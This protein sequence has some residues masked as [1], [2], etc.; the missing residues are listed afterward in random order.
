MK[1]HTQIK[2]SKS[3]I[4]VV[5]VLV[6]AGILQALWGSYIIKFYNKQNKKIENDITSTFLANKDISFSYLYQEMQQLVYGSDILDR[7]KQANNL[8]DDAQST[9]FSRNNSVI[10]TKELFQQMVTLY[11]D[12]M[13]FFYYD[14]SY[15]KIVEYGRMK[16]GDRTHFI[17]C[18]QN[19]MKEGKIRFSRGGK[20][21]L[22]DKKYL[23]MITRGKKGY[24]GCFMKNDDFIN[25]IMQIFS[26]TG[27]TVTLYDFE[28]QIVYAQERTSKG[29]MKGI[30][31]DTIDLENT[32]WHSMT[33]ADFKIAVQI[34]MFSLASPL[35][36]QFV[37]TIVFVIYLIS[38]VFVIQYTRKNI[39]GQAKYFYNN[40]MMFSDKVKFQEE[41][42]I[43]EFS[44]AGKVL[45]KLADEI[46][47]LKINVY[48]E[49]LEKKKVELD[50][51]QLQ[52]RPHFY[53]NC[54]NVINSLAQMGENEQIQKIS[55]HVS[56]YLRFIFNKSMELL[57]I[58]EELYFVKNYLN[59]I[60]SVNGV[61]CQLN[62]DLEDGLE[63]F[64]VPPL[65]IQTFVENSVKH[66]MNIEEVFS[67]SIVVKKQ[68]AYV[69]ITITDSGKGIDSEIRELWNKGIYENGDK[70]YHVGI[71]NAA[72]R[73][74]MLYGAKASIFFDILSQGGSKTVIRLP[75]NEIEYGGEDEL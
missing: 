10:A 45:N 11:G 66:G 1:K 53:I 39:L 47:K 26:K 12:S 16:I 51:A 59:V 60:D 33:Y 50:Y 68:E 17:S 36:L 15:N 73:M 41:N 5:V 7:V 46:N 31:I 72:K 54:L 20:W 24:I 14:P 3:I 6:I 30:A 9:V 18:I 56:K 42:G 40:L 64:P 74:Q 62:I 63:Q 29:E 61:E 22:Y 52:V 27:V 13:N 32:K 49:Q 69:E 48:E 58:A 67:V 37:F 4:V 2:L 23:C 65:I 8:P 75:Y 38:V 57:P 21:Y 25:E 55:L 71:R 19:D 70:C 35:W 44:E 34:P 28:E 43:V